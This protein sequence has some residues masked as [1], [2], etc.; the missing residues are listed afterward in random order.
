MQENGKNDVQLDRKS[1]EKCGK[2]GRLPE[3]KVGR[4]KYTLQVLKDIKKDVHEVREI[5]RIILNGL[6]GAGYYH[7]DAPLIE[8]LACRDQVDL[9]ILAA[10]HEAGPGGIFPKDVA[11]ELAQYG[12]EYYDV[13]RRILRMN[14]RL[15]QEAGERLFE[16]RGHRWTLTR[17]AVDV[18]GETEEEE[19]KKSSSTR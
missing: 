17:F 10:V 1:L 18:W 7:F 14:R 19:F 8:K 9:E 5:Q 11:K 6:K 15:E 3:D 4:L 12:L 13:S 16:K 2:K